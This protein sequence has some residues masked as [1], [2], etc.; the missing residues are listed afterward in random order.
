MYFLDMLYKKK[1]LFFLNIKFFI[2][3]IDNEYVIKHIFL[4]VNRVVKCIL[5]L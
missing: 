3:I 1:Q 5:I 2:Y 4:I